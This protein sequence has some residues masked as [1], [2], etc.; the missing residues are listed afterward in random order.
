MHS[1]DKIGVARLIVV[2]LTG[3]AMLDA[4]LALRASEL[5]LDDVTHS[6]KSSNATKRRS[7]FSIY[8]AV[9]SERLVP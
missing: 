7:Q 9:Q 8:Y 2:W 3:T 1:G 4:G 5:K 6:F